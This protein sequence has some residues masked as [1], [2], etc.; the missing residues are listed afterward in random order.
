MIISEDVYIQSHSV[1]KTYID[2]FCIW[3]SQNGEKIP[4]KQAGH[5]YSWQF[6][7]RRALFNPAFMNNFS[8]LF[9][10]HVEREIGHFDF[11]IAGLETASTPMISALPIFCR[12]KFD[13]NL[14]GFSVRKERKEYGLH[15]WEEGIIIDDLPVLIVDDLSNSGNSILKCYSILFHEL[16]CE[17][18]DY[19]FTCV[20]KTNDFEKTSNDKYFQENGI[21]HFKF[22]SPF[23]LKDFN[24]TL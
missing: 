18:I 7:L 23:T 15:N 13:I 3:R 8:N 14:N 1:C 4:A 11:Q 22:L 12:N 5:F 2:N 21:N 6:Y 19:V 17:T 24:L 10:Y 20:N 9:V 16:K